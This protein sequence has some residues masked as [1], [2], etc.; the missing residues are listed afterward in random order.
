VAG[1]AIALFESDIVMEQLDGDARDDEDPR[2]DAATLSRK[3]PR[4]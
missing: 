1:T 2:D 4:G 3:S